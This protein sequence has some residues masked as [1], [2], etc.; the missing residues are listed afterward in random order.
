MARSLFTCE[1]DGKSDVGLVTELLRGVPLESKQ[2]EGGL[3][4]AVKIGLGVGLS[5][6]LLAVVAFSLFI[7]R[8]RKLACSA[9]SEPP[10]SQGP[11][12]SP[13]ADVMSQ[14][15]PIAMPHPQPPT[16]KPTH[17]SYRP[18]APHDPPFLVAQGQAK[19]D[20]KF[21]PPPPPLVQSPALAHTQMVMP[22][23]MSTTPTQVS[24][25]MEDDDDLILAPVPAGIR[26]TTSPQGH[27]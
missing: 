15:S 3:P 9:N 10:S 25:G 26:Y 5:L 21:P 11:H 14:P 20:E 24:V 1:K 4:L 8:Q 6:V 17:M 13:L 7:Y 18:V 19:L 12:P 16:S 22:P 23:R 27:A 2:E